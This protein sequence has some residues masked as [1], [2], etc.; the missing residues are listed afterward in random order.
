VNDTT[1]RAAAS[2]DAGAIATIYNQAVL[3]S[4]A[5]FDLEPE[6]AAARRRWLSAET[7][8][9]CLVGETG[10]LVV[11]WS[12]LVAW[13]ARGGYDQT[14]EISIYIAPGVRRAGLGLS[15]AG[16]ALE[17]AP[18]LGLRAVVAQICA[19]ND[20]GLSLAD[21]LGFARVGVLRKVG[22][23]FGRPLDVVIC[24]LLL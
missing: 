23:K 19:E 1:I 5:T 16:A 22:H 9:L 4:T 8:R 12:S 20:A 14:V 18:G 17:V 10:G 11:G 6:T 21:R 7:T 2:A 24:E 13:S 15:L 3:T